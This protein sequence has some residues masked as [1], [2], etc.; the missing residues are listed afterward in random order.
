MMLNKYFV[1]QGVKL[2][3]I[4]NFIRT[5]FPSGDYSSIDLQTT[6]L[7]IKIVIYTNKPGKIIGRGGKNID[8]ITETLKNEFEL[9]N[10]QIDVKEISSPDLD[11]K[12]VAKQI[13]SAIER[14]YNYKK[15]GNLTIKRIMDAG[16]LGAEIVISGKVGGSKAATAKF[17]EGHI[18]HSGELKRQLVDEGYE[19]ARTKPGTI[20]IHVRIMK[21]GRD[22]TGAVVKRG[23][24]KEAL[25]K[26][27]V[28]EELEKVIKEDLD[29]E[30]WAEGD[31]KKE[32]EA[33]GAKGVKK[34]Q[35]K[36]TKK[37]G[38]GKPKKGK[39]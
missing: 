12:I 23:T 1:G 16:A 34:V 20:G 10:P 3:S 4:E 31:V 21:E 8:E 18:K 15:I 35:R 36:K 39:E 17:I 32:A 11:S 22:I 2:A 13:R 28:E 38:K 29:E 9:E 37:A 25:E 27:A 30:V 5:K 33:K 14:G 26:K 6:P 7:G 24:E 19:E